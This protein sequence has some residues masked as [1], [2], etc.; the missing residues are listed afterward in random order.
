MQQSNCNINLLTLLLHFVYS[1]IVH[2]TQP[3][4]SVLQGIGKI[5][6][7]LCPKQSLRKA[8]TVFVRL[9]IVRSQVDY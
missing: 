6:I 8:V 3:S 2:L 5:P 7:A 1:G 9:S 4:P